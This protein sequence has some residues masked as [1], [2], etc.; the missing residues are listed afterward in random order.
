MRLGQY[1]DCFGSKF[2]LASFLFAH[3]RTAETEYTNLPPA[4]AVIKNNEGEEERARGGG[5]PLILMLT[6]STEQSLREDNIKS[7]GTCTLNI[8]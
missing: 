5:C 1:L 3:V 6:F 7:V 2:F 4:E 8:R